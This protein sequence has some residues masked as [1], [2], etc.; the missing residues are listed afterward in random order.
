MILLLLLALSAAPV[1]AESVRLKDGN[2]VPAT[3]TK[4]DADTVEL[5]IK[6]EFVDPDSWEK[7]GRAINDGIL[8]LRNGIVLRGAITTVAAESI[9]IRIPKTNVER[10]DSGASPGAAA[11]AMGL[12]YGTSQ[13]TSAPQ[14]QAAAPPADSWQARLRQR[15]AEAAEPDRLDEFSA[16]AGGFLPL[17]R[18]TIDGTDSLAGPGYAFGAQYL[19]RAGGDLLRQEN[20]S[21]AFGVGLERLSGGSHASST[22]ITNG[23]TTSQF[24]STVLMLLGRLSADEGRYRLHLL[25]GLGLHWT[26]IQINSTPQ[27]GF[28]WADTGTTETRSVVNS[29][30]S[31]AAL[32][33]QPGFDAQVTDSVWVG[34]GLAYVFLGPATYDPSPQAQSLGATGGSVAISGFQFSANVNVQF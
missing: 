12:G 20:P 5:Q 17:T 6:K 15:S 19:R 13:S 10:I 22:L 18:I 7:L 11:S 9:G 34:A 27:P 30:K 32:M 3:V 33:L 16:E 29:T 2:V 4:T 26:N 31:A 23:F 28:A 8:V 24:D 21:A 25:G 1:G 14:G